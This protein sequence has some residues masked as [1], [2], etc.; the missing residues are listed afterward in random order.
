MRI[1]VILSG[2]PRF[3]EN[4]FSSQ[5]HRTWAKPHHVEYFGHY[6]NNDAE[7]LTSSWSTIENLNLATDVAEQILRQYPGIRMTSA[8]PQFFNVS[9]LDFVGIPL[10]SINVGQ[11][12]KNEIDSSNTISM[13]KSIHEALLLANERHN[14]EPFDLFVL[15]RWDLFIRELED[16]NNINAETVS[17]ISQ[18]THFGDNIILGGPTPINSL[19]A[20]PKLREINQIIVEMQKYTYNGFMF[21]GENIKYI[22]MKINNPSLTPEK[23]YGNVSLIRASSFSP[24]EKPMRIN[25]LVRSVLSMKRGFSFMK[26]WTRKNVNSC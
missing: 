6:W 2:Q 17:T 19:D 15:S 14:E 12:S 25:L 23:V 4:G 22:S 11:I 16:A 24:A 9:T 13:M 18:F 26:K 7:S 5:S 20:Y 1:A 10:S 3:I 8:A 21:V